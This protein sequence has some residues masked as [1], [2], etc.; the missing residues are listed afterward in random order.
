MKRI[1]S[2]LLALLLCALSA[3]A[4]FAV[5]GTDKAKLYDLYADG[6]LFRQNAPAIF[7]GTAT[8]TSV[9]QCELLDST[10]AVVAKAQGPV[11]KSNRFSVSFTAP[12]GSYSEY[13]VQ[14]YADGTPFATLRNVVFGEL[15]LASGQSNMDYPLGQS[16][17]GKG[18]METGKTGS[19]WLR[20]YRAPTY[21]RYNG[22]EELFPLDAQRD[23]EGGLWYDGT[24]GQIYSTS[25]V[26][27]FFAQKMQQTLDMPFGV[28]QSSLGGSSI[29]SWLS[30]DAIESDDAV[31]ADLTAMDAY[32]PEESWS[33]SGH[34]TYL[35]MTVNYNKKIAPLGVF[36]PAG[37]IWYQGETEIM[38]KVSPEA[39]ARAFDCMQRKYSRLFGF[40]EDARM[41]FVYTQIAPFDYGGS[42]LQMMND[43]YAKMQALYPD[44]RAVTPIYDVSKAYTTAVGYIHPMVKKTVGERMAYA[45]AGLVYGDNTDTCSAAY[46]SAVDVRDG[47]VYVTLSHTG[48]GL[49]VNGTR[50]YG[51]AVCGADG[52]YV[53][54]EAQIVSA[55]TI[56][57]YA[58]TVPEPTA[59][60]YAFA[61]TD[62]QANL[63]ATDA[64][65]LA[66]PVS[67][68]ITDAD[69]MRQV[70]QGREWTSCDHADAWHTIDDVNTGAY[71]T[72]Q[73]TGAFLHWTDDAV[74]G[75]ALHALAYEKRFTVQP[76]MLYRE[77]R[78][79][80]RMPDVDHDFSHYRQISFYIRN[81]GSTPLRL[82]AVRFYT[83]GTVWYAPA[84]NGTDDP[85]CEIPADGKWREV[86]LD[87][88][89]LYLFGNECGVT[90][91]RAKLRNIR[92]LQLRF[93]GTDAEV[94]LDEFRFTP[95]GTDGSGVRFVARFAAADNVWEMFCAVCM[96]LL[97]P[98]DRILSLF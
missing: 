37:M 10:G 22:S 49:A 16:E 58:E 20:F 48:N 51:F 25:A 8:G 36:R 17:T 74:C 91:S 19:R 59:A 47:S 95:D 52:I 87:M 70:W 9:V 68:F 94:D 33:E 80:R 46:P 3:T 53:P 39:Y 62:E 78:L 15:W 40:A 13:T 65:G 61:Q 31:R 21:A 55:D 60:S 6:M 50:L 85:D 23:I 69:G 89:T 93:T 28:L 18:M 5:N 84:V 71:D 26:A 56:C 83:S 88:D 96:L 76:T 79:S 44:S 86:T 35:D 34:N 64:D 1:V 81:T 82:D 97:N 43:G 66:M 4:A 24:N 90:A 2:C 7:A 54:A 75:K 67:P 42:K 11:N 30:R 98:L 77:D 32:F 14:M 12:K 73:A 57:V 45:A 27:F 41:P 92:D 72:W 38:R 63:Y 29:Y